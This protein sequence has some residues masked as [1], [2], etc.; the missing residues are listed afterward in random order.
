[1]TPE[2][3]AGG[4]AAAPHALLRLKGV[5]ALHSSR[6]F[7]GWVV[8]SVHRAPWVVVRRARMCG[9]RVP[10]GVRG[11]SRAERFAALTASRDILEHV[12]PQAVAAGRLWQSA[13][14]RYRL[15]GSPFDFGGGDH[16]RSRDLRDAGDRPAA[17]DLSSSAVS[18][19][20]TPRAISI[21]R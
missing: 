7:P 3:A 9:D 17:W 18:R 10:V 12:T 21:S 11:D 8:E 4:S 19:P 14:R 6:T 13:A 20:R 16:E 5:E 1:M 2:P 15:A